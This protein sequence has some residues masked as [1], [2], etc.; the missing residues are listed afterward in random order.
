MEVVDM[1]V[2]ITSM[3]GTHIFR[4]D[5]MTQLMKCTQW[6]ARLCPHPTTVRKMRTFLKVEGKMG[7]IPQT[8]LLYN[9]LSINWYMGNITTECHSKSMGDNTYSCLVLHQ[10]ISSLPVSIA[11]DTRCF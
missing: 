5:R 2:K 8:H 3:Q 11:S 10:K 1:E 4:R 7:P 9:I 6:S